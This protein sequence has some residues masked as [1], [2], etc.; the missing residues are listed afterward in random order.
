MCA[1]TKQMI[2]ELK[3]NLLTF[4]LCAYAPETATA[5]AAILYLSTSVACLMCLSE[6]EPMPVFCG[7]ETEGGL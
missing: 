4:R 3:V 7:K 5:T 1:K 6:Q 2:T